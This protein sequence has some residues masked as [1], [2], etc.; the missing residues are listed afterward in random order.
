MINELLR[1]LASKDNNTSVTLFFGNNEV[2][3]GCIIKEVKEGHQEVRFIRQEV[4][5]NASIPFEITESYLD[6]PEDIEVWTKD[7]S[8]ITTVE[9]RMALAYIV[10]VSQVIGTTN[11]DHLAEPGVSG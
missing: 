4:E 11:L 7:T 3:D 8:K 1:K 2:L 9:Y 5:G 6:S 10:G